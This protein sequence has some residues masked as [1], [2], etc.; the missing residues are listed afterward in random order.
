MDDQ[1]DDQQEDAFGRGCVHSPN[2]GSRP[3]TSEMALLSSPSSCPASATDHGS[4]RYNL[5]Q[6]ILTAHIHQKS[7]RRDIRDSKC[8]Y[9]ASVRHTRRLVK[10]KARAREA[11][12]RTR[13]V[14]T[15]TTNPSQSSRALAD[16]STIRPRL[17]PCPQ[18]R[19]Q[20]PYR[21]AK[22]TSG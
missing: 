16:R 21:I 20:D 7:C 18:H 3:E 11:G 12:W 1:Q 17:W 6:T 14:G 22:A 19:Q 8:G 4:S 15:S 2:R 5:V 10:N 9:C 13:W